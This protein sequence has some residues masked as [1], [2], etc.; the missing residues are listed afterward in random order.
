MFACVYDLNF[1]GKKTE[2]LIKTQFL[3]KFTKINKF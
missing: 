1:S 3:I 2:I